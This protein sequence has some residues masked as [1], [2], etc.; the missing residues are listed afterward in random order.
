[1]LAREPRE[2]GPLVRRVVVDVHARE[3]AAALGEVVDELLERLLLAGAIVRPEA[4]VGRRSVLV[5]LDPAEEV[6][7]PAR[8]LEPRMALEVE[9][10]VAGRRLGQEGEAALRLLREQIDAVLARVPAMQL[11]LGLVAEP[12]EG[13][14]P[15]LRDARVRRRRA[16]RL[17]RPDAAGEEPVVLEPRHARD[18]RQ[19]VVVLPLRLA[20][21]QELAEPAVLD[22]VRIRRRAAV[23]DDRAE[24]L[25]HAAVVGGEVLRPEGLALAGAGDDVHLA[26][27]APG[28]ARDL[29]GV[30]A[31]L[32][33]VRGPRVPRELRVDDLV[34]PVGLPLDE[35]RLPQPPAVGEDGLV[36]DVRAVAQRG[37]RLGSRPRAERSLALALRG[38]R[39]RRPPTPHP[40]GE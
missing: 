38:A 5:Q 3:A 35:V 2:R 16:E 40:C 22:R 9:P 24:A 11:E 21:L 17:H 20:P 18:E 12:R 37:L 6:L 39:G 28:D 13:V 32:E 26:G 10:D 8:R 36:D 30:E 33:H 4:S 14:G 29:L 15:D 7:E 19:V 27:R 31:E 34:A 25:A 1:M 23:F